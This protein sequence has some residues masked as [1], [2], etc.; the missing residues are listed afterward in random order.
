MYWVLIKA[1]T[2]KYFGSFSVALH[3]LNILSFKCSRSVLVREGA[4]PGTLEDIT[5][6]GF[7]VR[8]V[9]HE[10]GGGAFKVQ[11]DTLVFSN[12]ADQRLYKQSLD[13]G[14]FQA[15]TM[16]SLCAEEK[17]LLTKNKMPYEIGGWLLAN[18]HDS[19]SRGAQIFLLSI[20]LRYWAHQHE[21]YSTACSFSYGSCDEFV[22]MYL[23]HA[24]MYG[25]LIYLTFGTIEPFARQVF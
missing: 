14:V 24:S 15:W 8:T 18:M 4:Q 9:V 22:S 7:N 20:V 6:A 13:G 1:S 11:G 17:L 10:Y 19:M 21:L 12:Y 2:N 23:I 25:H 3:S 5:P 16:F